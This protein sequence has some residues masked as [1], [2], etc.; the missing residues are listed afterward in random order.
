MEV[1]NSEVNPQ[2]IAR[3]CEG[4]YGEG[5]RKLTVSSSKM[6]RQNEVI[7]FIKNKVLV[8]R[9]VDFL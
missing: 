4:V 7:A 6:Q 1:Q 9:V 8:H 2:H 3:Y 5:G